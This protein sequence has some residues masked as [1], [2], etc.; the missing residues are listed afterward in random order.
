MR[1]EDIVQFKD[2]KMTI[3][4]KFSPGYVSPEQPVFEDEQPIFAGEQPTF[5]TPEEE[6]KKSVFDRMRQQGELNIEVESFLQKRRQEESD[7]FMKG[8]TAPETIIE[9]PQIDY[10]TLPVAATPKEQVNILETI[11]KA[12]VEPLYKL[13]FKPIPGLKQIQAGLVGLEERA[14]GLVEPKTGLMGPDITRVTEYEGFIP[15]MVKSIP[16]VMAGTVAEMVPVSAFDLATFY[17][18][19][20]VYGKGMQILS[21]YPWFTAPLGNSLANIGRIIVKKPINIRTAPL[22]K[23]DIIQIKSGRYIIEEGVGTSGYPGMIKVNS[24]IS[25]ESL[26]IPIDDLVGIHWKTG[27]P[28]QGL[29]DKINISVAAATRKPFTIEDIKIAGTQGM[30][31]ARMPGDPGYR[32]Y[33]KDVVAKD[34]STAEL[35]KIGR[36]L[37]GFRPFTNPVT[38]MLYKAYDKY[39]DIINR[40]LPEVFKKFKSKEIME[41]TIG[42]ENIKEGLWREF[43]L[44]SGKILRSTKLSPE[45]KTEIGLVMAG[46]ELPSYKVPQHVLSAVKNY[47][48]LTGRI[49]LETSNIF[50]RWITDGLIPANKARQFKFLLKETVMKHIGEYEHSIY[51][52]IVQKGEAIPTFFSIN[53]KTIKTGMFK[54]KMTF[55]EWGTKSLQYEGKIAP[56]DVIKLEGIGRTSERLLKDKGYTITE[57]AA[58]DDLSYQNSEFLRVMNLIQSESRARNAIFDAKRL[59]ENKGLITESSD[60]L[61]AIGLKAKIEFGWLHRAD[62][63]ADITLKAQIQNYA[64]TKWID[65]IARDNTLFSTTP[66]KGWFTLVEGLPY[67]QEQLRGLGPL[68]F[69][70]INPVLKDELIGHIAGRG[71]VGFMDRFIGELVALR[72]GM[73]VPTSLKASTRNY[74]AGATIQLDMAGAPL[75]FPG[76]ALM[77][78]KTSADFFRHIF[79][80][81]APISEFWAKRGLYGATWPDVEIVTT[82]KLY[83]KMQN[84]RSAEDVSSLIDDIVAK[85]GKAYQQTKEAIFGWYGAIDNLNKTYLAQWALEKGATPEQAVFFGHKWQLDYR[86]VAKGVEAIRG[87][88]VGAAFPF[89]SYQTLILPRVV[90]TLLTRPWVLAKYPIAISA[91]NMYQKAKL[92][93]SDEEEALYRPEMLKDDQYAYIAGRKGDDIYYGTLAYLLP[94]GNWKTAFIDTQ[95]IGNT[96][97]TGG[98]YGNLLGLIN[99]KN[100]FTD[101]EIYDTKAL[102]S[103]RKE[104]RNEYIKQMF[105]A[106]IQQDVSRFIETIER[107]ELGIPVPVKINMKLEVGRMIGF[108]VYYGGINPIFWKVKNYQAKI[109]GYKAS[110]KK[111][112]KKAIIEKDAKKISNIQDKVDELRTEI[113]AAESELKENLGLIKDKKLLEKV[114]S[115]MKTFE[116]PDEELEEVE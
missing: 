106:A 25:G 86:F 61:K 42:K 45:M 104:K 48:L 11:F 24:P 94:I 50:S 32:E 88:I 37:D 58:I 95:A 18:G 36:D 17:I 79:K 41:L 13:P 84:I 10:K 112:V 113:I 111:Y 71:S 23:S 103:I 116:E 12:Q 89:I 85:S 35:R 114:M 63:M 33:L 15:T 16:S 109:R 101:R 105:A 76:N 7:N 55:E 30:P 83:R 46:V 22:L 93:I 90:E 5:P 20:K 6:F 110:L 29:A 34:A 100:F 47:H 28:L 8:V 91:F 57:L 44:A 60:E 96:F 56:D 107:K 4:P 40:R 92:G 98:F 62:A 26:F 108:P 69:G 27:V 82:P 81:E 72:K 14:K 49:G 115:Y 68:N 52:G 97:K 51:P 65:A 3:L 1:L 73:L 54:R 80:K 75:W 87:G 39:S 38:K 19:A 74:L 9:K 66:K 70:Y 43:D 53:Q 102:P 21:K 64:N 67:K 99:N 59:V 77:Y 2:W 78:R 31:K